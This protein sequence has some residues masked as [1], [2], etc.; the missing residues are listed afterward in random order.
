M[1][2]PGER[3]EAT[4]ALFLMPPSALRW[5]LF[6]FEVVELVQEPIAR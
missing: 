3:V 4:C 1:P 5:R 6:L 2:P